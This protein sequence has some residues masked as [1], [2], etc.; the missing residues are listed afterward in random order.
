MH[1]FPFPPHDP[2][3]EAPR[4]LDGRTY[5]ARLLRDTRAAFVAQF[6]ESDPLKLDEAV[7]LRVALTRLQPAVALGDAD[8]IGKASKISNTLE[9]LSRQLGQSAAK[10]KEQVDAA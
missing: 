5:P 7:L 4:R 1:D 8:A 6:G 3:R 10:E 9:R 2:F